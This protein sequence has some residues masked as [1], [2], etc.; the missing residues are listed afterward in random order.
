VQRASRPKRVAIVSSNFWPERT[1]TSQTVGEFAKF[2]SDQGIEVRV[3]TALPYYPEWR[4]WD[5]YR[6]TL[7]RTD[8][9]NR[10]TVFRAWHFV[11]PTPSTFTRLLHELTLSVLGAPRMLQAMWGADLVYVVSP[12]LVFAFTG[13]LLALVER[14]RRVLV[15]KDVMPDAAIELGMLRNP[16][17]IAVSRWMA[18]CLY[19]WAGEIYTL[20]EGMRRRIAREVE[21]AGKVRIVPDT[22]DAAELEPVPYDVND[23][24]RRFVPSGTFAVLHTGNMGKK[25]D[26]EL[27]LRAADRLRD[28]RAVH[29]YVFGD[30]AAREP[31]LQLRESLRLNNVSLHPLQDRSM[32][33][34][35][36]SGA[37]VVLV[38]QL[39]EVVDIVVPSKLL[40]ALGAGAMIVAACAPD[41]ETARLVNECAGGL[42]IPASDDEALVRVLQRIR[43]GEV[44]VT[45]HRRRA[46][47]FAVQKF[48]RR[49][50]YGPLVDGYLAA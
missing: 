2:L 30:G 12:D 14:R 9:D 25:Q 23:F 37:D 48:D 50:V 18:R 46:R 33:R 26:L 32:L 29:F 34:H 31:F 41:S 36:L 13:M 4:I 27:L 35:M 21:S 24:R 19:R 49:A 1:G 45:Q 10:M 47:E 5:D 17:A 43:A 15:V 6:G 39:P 3:A 28:D 42:V 16:V 22:I 40:T 38:S 44:D 20:G 7:W 8:R 11:S